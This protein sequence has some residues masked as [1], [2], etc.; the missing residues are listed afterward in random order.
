[1]RVGERNDHHDCDVVRNSMNEVTAPFASIFIRHN[2]S[3]LKN[4][5]GEQ[6]GQIYRQER[7]CRLDV[8][9]RAIKAIL[10]AP[11]QS[12]ESASEDAFHDDRRVFDL[13]EI[14]SF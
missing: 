6:M 11:M 13:P 4:E 2:P 12:S 5:V 8:S 9:F 7:G 14:S 3:S 10:Y 1:V